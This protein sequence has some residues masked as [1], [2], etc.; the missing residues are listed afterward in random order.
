MKSVPAKLIL[1]CLFSATALFG[2]GCVQC[3]T[4]AHGAGAQGERALFR[5]MLVLLIPS[6][7]ILTGLGVLVYRNRN[8]GA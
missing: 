4:S 7:T 5:G 1:A 8:A 2:Q 3:A 6:I